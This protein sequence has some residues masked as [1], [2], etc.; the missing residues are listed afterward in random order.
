MTDQRR[1]FASIGELDAERP[2]GRGLHN[3]DRLSWLRTET[4]GCY[5]L[6]LWDTGLVDREGKNQL[7]YRLSLLNER[8]DVWEVI[9]AGEEFYPGVGTPI[10]SDRALAGVAGFCSLRPGDTDPEYFERYT[11][12]QLEFAEERGEELAGWSEALERQT[13][14]RGTR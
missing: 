13:V 1:Q 6:D 9:F 3:P 4:W 5:R 11:S 2:I 8:T 12:R 14:G 10:D 7:A